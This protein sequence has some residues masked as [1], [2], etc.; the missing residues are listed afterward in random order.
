M[1]FWAKRILIMIFVMVGAGLVI[2]F[3]PE[4]ELDENGNPVEKRS[5]ATNMAKFYEEFGM[6]SDTRINEKFGENVILLDLPEAS[7]DQQITNIQRVPT[8]SAKNERFNWRG[9]Y[10]TRAFGVNSTLKESATEYVRAEGMDLIW[11]LNQDFIVTSRFFSENTVAGM[12]QEIAGSID[13]NFPGDVK[14][15]FCEEKRVMVLTDKQDPA[16]GSTCV[17]VRKRR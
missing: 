10:E 14:L 2:I 17:L 5:I 13:V 6:V 8:N 12:L 15:Y 7:L 9:S 1:G 16:L 11:H 4:P 3:M